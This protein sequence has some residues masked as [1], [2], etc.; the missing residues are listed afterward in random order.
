MYVATF[1]SFKG[2]VGRTLALLNVAYE[3]AD[4]GLKI[5]VV[6][7]DLEA[8]AIYPERWQRPTRALSVGEEEIGSGSKGIVEYVGEY[9]RTM[10]SP[11]VDDY[12]VDATPKNCSGTIALMP[13]GLLDAGYGRRLNEIDWNDL[14][15][16]R[17]G[18]VMFEDLRAQ[19]A[20][21]A[22]DYVLLDSRTGFT[23]VGGICTRHL[24][25]AVVLMFRPDDQSLRGM[26]SVVEAIRTEG[27][28][29]RRK[30]PVQLHFAM[31][32]IPDADDEDGI[33]ERHRKTF[34][35]RLEIPSGRLLEIRHYQS[36]DL[37]T[38][39][40]YTDVRPRTKLAGSFRELAVRV[41]TRNIADREGVLSYLRTSR[42]RMPDR[43]EDDFLDRISRRYGEDVDVLGELADVHRMRGSPL[44]AAELLERIAKLETPTA[45]QL[46]NL[47]EARRFTRDGEGSLRALNAFFQDPWD[48][49]PSSD[50]RRYSL[51]RRGLNMLETLVVDRTAYV[52]GSPIIA[53]LPPAERASVADRLDLS[54]C[55]RRVAVGI[56]EDVL[57]EKE[58]TASLRRAWKWNLAFAR[59]AVGYFAQAVEAFRDALAE[60]RSQAPVPTA[61]NLAMALWGESR[62]ADSAAFARVLNYYDAEDDKEWLKGDPN[63]LQALAVA[64]R[65]GGRLSD[66]AEHLADAEKLIRIRRQRTAISCWSYTRVSAAAFHEHCNDIRRLFAGEHI[67]PV[68]MRRNDRAVRDSRPDLR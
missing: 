30:D 12:M 54:P 48:G 39:P 10:R 40:I 26:E 36:M 68:F 37:L 52:D 5:L 31:A 29:P 2:G 38:Q 3:L 43:Q 16:R 11:N 6:D 33:L 50:S 53:G 49:P 22:F 47:A 67:E 58:D 7:F 19:W 41:R 21:L 61:F 1:Y 42:H 44:K 46:I 32:A 4:S 64:E 45:E 23:D 17:D 59:V 60:P 20:E 51:V 28:T 35:K 63:K 62:S 13:S 34:R 66:A 57:R 27:P 56:L 15:T 24:P 14:Y 8:P 65:F 55:E 25:D 18:Y 9:L